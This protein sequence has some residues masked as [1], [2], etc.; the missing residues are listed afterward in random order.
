MYVHLVSKESLDLAALR[1]RRDA[2]L[3]WTMGIGAVVISLLLA[4]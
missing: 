3:A 4:Q 2:V 1:A